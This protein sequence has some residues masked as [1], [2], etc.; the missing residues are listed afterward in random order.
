MS[1]NL[2]ELP[3]DLPIPVDDAKCA[4]LVGME[5]PEINL[6]STVGISLNLREIFRQKS[7]LFI[8]PRAGS[9]LEPNSNLEL[10]SS[11]PGARGCTPQ[12]C[13]FRN[14]YSEFN[15]ADI[16]I[17][18]LSTQEP[19]IQKEFAERNRLPFPILS[20]SNCELAR[21]MNLPT[22]IFEGEEL[23]KRMA[24][25]IDENKIIKVFYPV[26]PPDR[27]AHEVLAWLKQ[28]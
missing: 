4:H 22:F 9:P 28:N 12:T 7:V 16:A 15:E 8:Y 3:K 21:A 25:V 1:K 24:L 27:N 23:I 11:I 18:G 19:H 26:F 6:I 5:M 20:D 17:Y 13:E 2:L 10:W 14:L